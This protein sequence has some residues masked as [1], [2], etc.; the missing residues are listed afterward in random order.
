MTLVVPADLTYCDFE[1]LALNIN[2]SRVTTK[3]V[4]KANYQ[5]SA[6]IIQQV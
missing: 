3:V 5:I 2:S 1:A 4:Q 6:M